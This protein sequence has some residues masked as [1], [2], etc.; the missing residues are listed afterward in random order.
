LD[1][2]EEWRELARVADSGLLQRSLQE[3]LEGGQVVALRH[4][5]AHLS[6]DVHKRVDEVQG[7]RGLRQLLEEGPHN[8]PKRQARAQLRTG[9]M[10]V[11]QKYNKIKQNGRGKLAGAYARRM[12]VLAVRDGRVSAFMRR[13][14]RRS[15]RMCVTKLRWPKARKDA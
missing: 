10:N 11:R 4:A 9:H 7:R 3:V 14:S 2:R 13:V 5:L 8:E 6:G 12:R 15:G 1:E